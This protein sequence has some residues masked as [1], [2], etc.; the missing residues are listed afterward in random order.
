MRLDHLVFA[1]RD[2]AAGT[3]W[4]SSKLG[5]APAGGGAHPL[6]G[7]HNSLWRLGAA[8]LEVIAPDPAAPPPDRPRWYALDTPQVPQTPVLWHWVVQVDDLAA[9][10]AAAPLDPGPALRV[11]RDTLFWDL[12]VPRDGSLHWGGAYPTLIQWPAEVTPPPQRLPDQGLSLLELRA[13]GPTRMRADLEGLGV[14]ALLDI[15][16]G[17]SPKLSARITR[18]DGRVAD[19]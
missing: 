10:S 2:L 15:G 19:F 11:T 14:A 9:A 4:M 6:M 12:T 13:T 1:A 5:C 18:P 17:A 8:Y 3:E 7:T 16:H